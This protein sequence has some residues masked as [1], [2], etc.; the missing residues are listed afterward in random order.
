LALDRSSLLQ[1]V[2]VNVL[3]CRKGV[4]TEYLTLPKGAFHN[5]DNIAK[6]FLF[7]FLGNR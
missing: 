3:K 1:T 6:M 7:S 4:Y 5:Q 2:W